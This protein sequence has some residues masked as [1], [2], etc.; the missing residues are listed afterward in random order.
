M[1]PVVGSGAVHAQTDVHARAAIFLDRRDP[2][3][4]P[5]IRRG[6]VRHAAVVLCKDPDLLIVDPDRVGEPDIVPHPAHFLHVPDGTVPEA[7][8]AELLFIFCFC[9]VRVEMD[10]IFPR[11]SG[12]LLHQVAG[13]AEG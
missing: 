8:Q 7:L 5:H 10:T 13:H 1:R 9:Q 2:R 6:T 3:R 4:Q 12:R 11:Q